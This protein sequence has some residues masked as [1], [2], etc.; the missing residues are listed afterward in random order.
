MFLLAKADKSDM[1]VS[2][3]AASAASLAQ[4]YASASQKVASADPLDTA[5][6]A[7]KDVAAEV[8]MFALKQA[9]EM[10]GQIVDLLV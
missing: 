3:N 5:G 4:V 7:Q 6:K 2:L 9:M 1:E 10:A 8:L